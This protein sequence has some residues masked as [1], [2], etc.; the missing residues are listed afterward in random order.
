M[1]QIR[2]G[3]ASSRFLRSDLQSTGT[4]PSPPFLESALAGV[5]VPVV[6]HG[7]MRHNVSIVVPPGGREAG[8]V[9]A[10][11]DRFGDRACHGSAAGRPDVLPSGGG[12][13]GQLL[14]E[15]DR[16]TTM[17]LVLDRLAG[18]LRAAAPNASAGN[19]F[20]GDTNSLSFIKL[21]CTDLALDTRPRRESRRTWCASPDDPF[22]H[23]WKPH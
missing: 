11:R 19:E 3:T 22:C 1:A 16:V 8:G 9:H 21:A 13:A 2:A 6:S 18:D 7:S 4:R 17:R 20:T 5:V 14:R 15:A 10:G 12:D 23:E